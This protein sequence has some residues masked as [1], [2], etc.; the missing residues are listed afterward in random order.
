MEYAKRSPRRIV[1]L[2]EGNDESVCSVPLG[3]IFRLFVL[4]NKPYI[5]KKY[6]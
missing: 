2:T 6:K 1:E 5:M 3:A 4:R